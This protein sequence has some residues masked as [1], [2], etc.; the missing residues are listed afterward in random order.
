MP[1]T[2]IPIPLRELLLNVR[3]AVRP[4]AAA[5]QIKIA[6]QFNGGLPAVNGSRATL[7]SVTAC[8]LEELIKVTPRERTVKLS[9]RSVKQSRLWGKGQW[10]EVGVHSGSAKLGDDDLR[11]VLKC[12]G[13]MKLAEVITDFHRGELRMT[14]LC[15]VKRLRG[16]WFLVRRGPR[17]VPTFALILGTTS[18]RAL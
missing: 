11:R 1:H 15:Q 18:R 13:P 12:V 2:E 10:V 3:S 4:I 14:L 17:D 8:L 5:R 16:C 9:A 7:K 6:T